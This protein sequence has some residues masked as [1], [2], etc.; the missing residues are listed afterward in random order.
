MTATVL[1]PADAALRSQQADAV[2]AC[3]DRHIPEGQPVALLQFPWDFNVGNHMM[4]VAAVDYLK[5]RKAPIAY[6]AHGNNFDLHAMVR[7]VGSGT[8]LFMGGVTVS[9]LWPRH[10]EVKRL[11]AEACPD[12]RLVSL[13]ST[14]L[15]VDD[16]DRR[17]AGEIFGA[18]RQTVLLARDPV[19]GASARQVFPEHVQVDTVH[20]STLMLPAQVRRGEPV[21]DVIW[22]ARDDLEGTGSS[23][24]SGVEV[25]DWAHEDPADASALFPGRLFSRAR[26]LAPLI[27]PLANRQ[28]GASYERFA[29]HVLDTGNRRLDTGRVL[30]TDRLHPHILA[31]L[32]GQH[33][34]VLPDRFGKNRAVF[35]YTSRHYSTVHWADTADEALDLARALARHGRP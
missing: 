21:H 14:M 8:I 23:A 25:F 9:R 24:P 32:R 18:H 11:V 1:S 35:E 30:V 2:R 5:R 22:L 10:A 33:S 13:P 17:Q 19:S 29:R 26:K 4:W 34:V 28:I 6:A 16:D 3:F 31:A 15:F 12:N 20:D 27:G 7:A